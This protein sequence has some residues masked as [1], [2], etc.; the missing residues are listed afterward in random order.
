MILKANSLALL[1]QY[2]F[3]KGL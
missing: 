1:I 3:S 2:L